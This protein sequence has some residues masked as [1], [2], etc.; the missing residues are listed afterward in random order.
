MRSPDSNKYKNIVLCFGHEN[1]NTITN[2]LRK[3]RAWNTNIYKKTNNDRYL[4]IFIFLKTKN[5]RY[6]KGRTA[7]EI[8]P[9]IQ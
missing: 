6:L 3:S 7:N 4:K 1:H 2:L 9:Y 8:Y 5:N